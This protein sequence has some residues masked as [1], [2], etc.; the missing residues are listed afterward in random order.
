MT[1]DY[2]FIIQTKIPI[3]TKTFVRNYAG[4]PVAVNPWANPINNFR[5]IAVRLIVE[6]DPSESGPNKLI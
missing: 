3:K 5:I 2:S 1:S 6:Q 4:N